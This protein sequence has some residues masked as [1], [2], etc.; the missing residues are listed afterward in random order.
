M[1]LPDAGPSAIRNCRAYQAAYLDASV[2]CTN[3]QD[4]E[5]YAGLGDS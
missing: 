5:K 3:G 1:A 2:L 4:A